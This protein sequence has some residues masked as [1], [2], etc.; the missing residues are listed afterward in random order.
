MARIQ[1]ELKTSVDQSYDIEIEK[2]LFKRI[3]SDLKM[4]RFV[5]SYVVITDAKVGRLYAA[6]LVAALKREILFLGKIVVPAGEE[7]K[8][9]AEMQ[10]VMESMIELG[11]HRKTGVIALGGGMIGDLAG[12]VAASYM[13]G[14][15]YVQVPTTLLGMVDSSVG[16]KVAI[17]L[18]SGKNMMGAFWQPKKVY[19]DPEVLSLLPMKQWKAGLGEV[20][21]YGAIKDRT[22]WDFLEQNVN[23]FNKAPEDFFPG[24]WKV[25][26]EMIRR[27]V[28]I[29]TEVV[30]KDEKEENLR[31]I[32]NY[33]HTFAH[34]IEL[35]SDYKVLHGEAVATGMRMAGA[36][37][38]QLR[39]MPA[40]ELEKQNTL[41]DQLG[42][43]KAKT[44]G[45]IKDFIGHMK[46]D[47]K[48]DEK[49]RLV[50]VDRLGR[51]RQDMGKYALAVDEKVVKEVL[52]ETGLIDDKEVVIPPSP[53]ER[54]ND[55][56]AQTSSWGAP[57]Y[58]A[59]PSYSGHSS[60]SSNYSAPSSYSSPSPSSYSTPSSY[61]SSHSQ[62]GETD[63]Q[64]RLREMRE[65]REQAQKEGKRWL[66]G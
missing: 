13:R 41:L 33:G 8:S 17:D 55:T 57:S 62:E 11:A 29:K 23:V 30:M 38:L 19:I 65:R 22:L 61:S 14:I 25:V 5:E 31:K 60:L 37:A 1:V 64:R 16:G 66:P 32:L 56:V 9:F 51:C 24:D 48:S 3:A 35:M 4:K 47:K 40:Q 53:L 44:K 39:V 50:L 27:C 6:G 54:G 58:G 59:S 34:V 52:E 10:K 21:K 63:L 43:G 46:K 28:Q 18:P 45:L 26:E 12:F 2:G 42:L 36:I 20:L 49:L 15:P 7:G